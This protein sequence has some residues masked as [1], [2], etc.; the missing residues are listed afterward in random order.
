METFFPLLLLFF[1]VEYMVIE[2]VMVMVT[3][4]GGILSLFETQNPL[5]G[6][7]NVPRASTDTLVRR[8]W[9]KMVNVSL[10]Y[11]FKECTRITCMA[12]LQ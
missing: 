8:K 6:L 9:V 12:I 7:E 5:C 2:V 1:S 3:V 11:P 10:N 4:F